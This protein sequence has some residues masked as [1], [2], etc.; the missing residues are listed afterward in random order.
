M[1]AVADLLRPLIARMKQELWKSRVIQTDS[2]P[3][4]VLI[5]GKAKAQTGHLWVYLTEADPGYVIFDF[6]T[7]HTKGHPQKFLADYTGYV[8]ADAYAGYDGLF[9]DTTHPK[10]EIGCWA[11]THRYFEAARDS[12]PELACQALGFSGALFGIEVRN[13]TADLSE[14]E[15]LAVRQ[16][17]SVPILVDFKHWLDRTAETALPKSP[18]GEAVRY[19]R[20]QWPALLRY[21]EAGFLC[22]ENNASERMNK[23]IA[24]G[25]KNWLFLGSPQGGATAAILFSVTATCRRLEMDVFAYLRDLLNRLPSQPPDQFD[26]LLPDRWLAAH[27]EARFPPQRRRSASGPAP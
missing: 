20:N 7:D 27:P 24:R 2:T 8:Q 1:A 25:R 16:Q 13:R 9:G 12:D 26:E 6:S 17:Q 4:N 15:V 19:A 22:M 23:I 10:V 14:E 11:H 5:D 18:L 3:V 21:T